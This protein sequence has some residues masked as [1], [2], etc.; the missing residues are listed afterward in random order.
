ML[1]NKITLFFLLLVGC[2]SAQVKDTVSVITLTQTGDTAIFTATDF[3]TLVKENHPLSKQAR[4]LIETADAE[5]LKAGGAFD[6]KLFNQTDQKYFDDKRYYN[7]QNSGLE[8]PAWFGLKA[9]TGYEQ[10]NGVFLNNQNTLPA[11]GLWY[12]DVSLTVGKGLFIDQ[13]RAML[14]QAQIMQQSADFEVQLLLNDVYSNALNAYWEWYRSYNVF[15]IF[16]EG[17]ELAFTRFEAVK[18][19][20]MIGEEPFID[21]LEAYI[22]YQTRLLSQQKAEVDFNYAARVLETYLWL[23]GSIPLEL[24]ANTLPAYPGDDAAFFLDEQWLAEHP[25]IKVYD[26]KLEQLAIAQRLNRENLKP[27]LDVNYK[28]LNEPVAGDPFLNQYS[29]SNYS[30][31][32]TASF[33]IFLRKERA[34]IRKT[35][36]KLR[37][38]EYQQQFKLRDIENKVE[39]LQLELGLTAQQLMETRKMVNNYEALLNAEIMK[40]ENGESSLFLINQREIKY[41]E[42][43]EKQVSLEAKLKQVLIKLQAVAGVLSE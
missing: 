4:L 13:R 18:Q 28:F 29:P 9:K 17:R 40:F 39:A 7:L 8:I 37:D 25:Q 20:A 33:P 19:N 34:E 35:D 30:W 6:P 22:Q 42:S 27:Q 21:T 32:L 2:I 14:K 11:S 12:A 31:G 23:D 41:L 43:S 5:R 24:A 3:F 10:N 1:K 16:S 38:T 26:L 15:Q 36:V